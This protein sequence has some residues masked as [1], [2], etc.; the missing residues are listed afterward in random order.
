MHEGRAGGQILKPGCKPDCELSSC[1]PDQAI[2][3]EPCQEA[4]KELEVKVQT[5]PDSSMK[6][7]LVLLLG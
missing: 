6:G 3:L 4:E 2:G 7:F 5:S 1:V